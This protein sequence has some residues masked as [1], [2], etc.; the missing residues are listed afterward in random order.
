[1]LKKAILFIK[2]RF[3]RLPGKIWDLAK[4]SKNS[5]FKKE[6]LD[7]NQQVLMKLNQR[8]IPTFTQLR[9][10][11]KFLTRTEKMQVLIVTL[12]FLG[13][14][15][16]FGWR[17]FAKNSVAVPAQGGEYTE[18]VVGSPHLINPILA[19]TDSERDI[20]KL[21][22]SGL[23]KA[24]ENG[25]LI[26]DLASGYTIDA[27]Q[28]VYTF[29]LRNNLHWHD[30]APLTAD[31]VIFTINSIQ[32]S[33]YKSPLRSSFNGVVA[34]KINDRTV[35]FILNQPF[36]AFL[37]VLTVGIIPEHLWY[38]IPAF[39]AALAELNVKPVGSGPYKFKSLTRDTSGSI[40]NL[41]LSSYDKYHFQPAYVSTVTFKFYPDFDTAV[42]ALENH[43]VD[44]LVFLPNEYKARFSK[45]GSLNLHSLQFP[46]YTALY[47]NPNNNSQLNNADFRKA[48]ASGIDKN[49]ILNEVLV[50]EGQ[51]MNTP[52]LPGMLGYDESIL[53]PA[54]D[55]DAARKILDDLGWKIEEGK[56]YRSKTA[57]D[58]TTELAVELTTLDQSEN[59]KVAT[60]IKENWESVGVRTDL[61]IVQRDRI[62]QDIIEPRSYQ[63]LLFGQVINV[64]S[65]LYPFWHSSQNKNPGLNLSVMAN[66]DIDEALTKSRNATTDED[67]INALK[68]FQEKLLELNFAVFLYNP[69][70]TYPVDDNVKGLENL[71]FINTTADRLNNINTWYI[72]TK[73][74]LSNN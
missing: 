73:R 67:K 52:L 36:P 47:F 61:N 45:I 68:T 1:M 38:S 14:A 39:G 74:V 56:T 13:S 64:N 71:S 28:K 25:E 37:S 34:K 16:F 49:R 27:E 57:D 33:D 22:F 3:S 15:G 60:I 40:K 50:G 12:I 5:L 23:M 31:D 59:V 4:K 54:F 46:R 32:N 72:R 6:P 42:N 17:V 30:G 21:V 11:S 69:T 2:E 55:L 18:G 43:N 9:Q 48:L 8:K 66:K 29:E 58:Q 24:D 7:V 65:G 26:P 63:V 70:Y 10:V 41:T 20:V 19:S 44:G 35:Q 53:A 51:I 62:R